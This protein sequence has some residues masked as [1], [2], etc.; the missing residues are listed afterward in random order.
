MLSDDA[1][2]RVESQQARMASAEEAPSI[3][4]QQTADL[5]RKL[6]EVLNPRETVTKALKRLRPPQA[7]AAKRGGCP[8]KDYCNPILACQYA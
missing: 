2:Q 7:P 4:P 5:F 6:V 8:A 3:T 1:R